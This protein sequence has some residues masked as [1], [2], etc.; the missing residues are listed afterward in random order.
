[1]KSARLAVFAVVL[2]SGAAQ[3]SY[4]CNPNDTC[5]SE[6]VTGVITGG[7]DTQGFSPPRVPTSP[8]TPSPQL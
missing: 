5:I 4:I 3:A 1:M 7:V 8:A 6:T 2:F